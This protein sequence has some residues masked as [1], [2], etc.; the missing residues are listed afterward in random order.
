MTK[1]IIQ[2]PAFNEVDTLSE[3]IAALPRNIDGVDVI[4]YLVVD[5]GSSDGT[6]EL[7]RQ[8]GVH[9]VVRS[10]KNKG[11]A[12]SFQIGLNHAL[13]SG[14]DIIV[15]TDA[16]NQYDGRDVVTIVEPI[17]NGSA[18]IVVGDRQ[19]ADSKSFSWKKRK[20]QKLGSYVVSRLSDNEIPDAVSGFRAISR[21][22][23]LR[24]HILSNF[25]YTTEMLIQAGRNKLAVVSVPIRTNQVDRPSRLFSTISGFIF[26]T[27]GTMLRTHAMYYPLRVFLS[28]GGLLSIIG[29]AAILRFLVLYFTGDGSGHIQSLVVGGTSLIVGSLTILL[30]V[31]ADLIARNRQ[32][33]EMVL[34][35]VKRLEYEQ[36]AGKGSS[37]DDGT[38]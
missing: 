19:V 27:G 7:A 37:Q 22:A 6:A 15:N 36:E 11:L 3:T 31:L 14:A 21:E 38:S 1:L 34:E 4:E 12:E 13:K 32:L 2:I 16:D 10:I 18:D 23:A 30:G 8:L 17:L 35:R 5:D 28:V 29:I 33:L 25:S 26:R 9:H 20:L 24:I